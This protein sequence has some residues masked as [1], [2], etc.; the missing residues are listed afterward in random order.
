MENEKLNEKN[1]EVHAFLQ[2][3]WYSVR[4]FSRKRRV[5]DVYNFYYDKNLKE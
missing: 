5:Q 4:L 2:R 3:Q 1:P